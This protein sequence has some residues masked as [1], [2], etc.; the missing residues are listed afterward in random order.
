V[1][2]GLGANLISPPSPLAVGTSVAQ[3]VGPVVN[4]F[5][6][7]PQTDCGGRPTPPSLQ[8]A[9]TLL[10]EPCMADPLNVYSSTSPSVFHVMFLNADYALP[11]FL[12]PFRGL[13]RYPRCSVDRAIEARGHAVGDT[14]RSTR[15]F[16]AKRYRFPRSSRARDSELKP[17]RRVEWQIR[18]DQEPRAGR[19]HLNTHC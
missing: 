2:L 8:S 14:R 17:G 10:T 7:R 16:L 18:H 4:I 19:P 13:T 9:G 15:F 3:K 11:S 6:C 12:I 1:N 5:T